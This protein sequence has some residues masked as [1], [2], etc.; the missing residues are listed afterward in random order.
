MI[1]C[2]NRMNDQPT[3][4]RYFEHRCV[5]NTIMKS[6]IIIKIIEISEKNCA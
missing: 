5:V 4:N 3:S 6:L 1:A 2:N